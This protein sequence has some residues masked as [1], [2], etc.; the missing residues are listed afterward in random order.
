M[1]KWQERQEEKRALAEENRHNRASRSA[2]EQL[3][4]LDFR[5]GKGVGAKRERARLNAAVEEVKKGKKKQKEHEN[6]S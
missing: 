3:A 1:N 2:K 4:E 6:D 5:L